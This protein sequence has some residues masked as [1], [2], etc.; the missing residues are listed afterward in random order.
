MS[1][2]IALALQEKQVLT[3]QR[4]GVCADRSIETI[5][6]I[7]GI[8]KAGAAYVPLDPAYPVERLQYMIEDS[9]ASVIV[10]HR[11]L[12]DSLP[13]AESSI[14]LL[15]GFRTTVEPI[16][17]LDSGWPESVGL[18]HVHLGLNRQAQRHRCSAP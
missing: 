6:A 11:H 3:G 5:A 14:L 15:D 10:A 1:N 13:S 9:Q 12:A 7:L 18:C 2:H 16:S 17:G 8:L 4:V